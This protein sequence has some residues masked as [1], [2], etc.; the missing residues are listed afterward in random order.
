MIWSPEVLMKRAAA[1]GWVSAA[2][3]TYALDVSEEFKLPGFGWGKKVK[4]HVRKMVDNKGALTAIRHTRTD[5]DGD[6][7]VVE[8]VMFRLTKAWKCRWVA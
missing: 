1:G 6:I 2:E 5:I 3:R 4:A 7:Y 8:E